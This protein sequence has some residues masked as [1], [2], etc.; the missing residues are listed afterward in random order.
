M[1]PKSPATRCHSPPKSFDK[2]RHSPLNLCEPIQNFTKLTLQGS[3]AALDL[4]DLKI[5]GQDARPRASTRH[6][7]VRRSPASFHARH[8]PTQTLHALS[9][10][11]R[12]KR[13]HVPS[14]HDIMDDVIL[15]YLGLTWTDLETWPDSNRLWKK[16]QKLWP[17]RTLTLT[18]KS[19]FSKMACFT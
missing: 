6:Q 9:R 2:P 11:R 13:W 10:V 4:Q 19:K 17:S 15:H 3:S 16:K 7:K 14:V 5:S 12:A 1:N 8:T 18:K